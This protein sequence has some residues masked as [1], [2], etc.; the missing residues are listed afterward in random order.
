MTTTL[1]WQSGAF[2]LWKSASGRWALP[3]QLANPNGLETVAGCPFFWMGLEDTTIEVLAHVG[4]VTL[5][6]VFKPAQQRFKARPVI[7][8]SGVD[9]HAGHEA[10][11]SINSGPAT[12]SVPVPAGRTT[13]ALT[14]LDRPML[15]APATRPGDDPRT[16]LVGVRNLAFAFTPVSSPGAGVME[17]E[18]PTGK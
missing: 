10:V 5:T 7:A 16:M 8:A 9:Q 2:R 3:L 17:Q 11:V 6:G 14:A 15:P 4:N 13:I 18:Q 12:L 1:L